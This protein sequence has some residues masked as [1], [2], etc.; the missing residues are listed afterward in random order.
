MKIQAEIRRGKGFRRARGR[1]TAMLPAGL[2]AGF[3]SSKTIAARIES[4]ATQ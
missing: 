3:I 2:R 1:L 4:A